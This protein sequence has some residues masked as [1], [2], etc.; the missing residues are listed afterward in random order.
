MRRCLEFGRIALES[1]DAPVGSLIVIGNEIIAEG[2][3]SVKSKN[4]PTAHAEIEAVR[5]ACVKSGALDL[6][7]ATLYT[8]VEP[9]VMCAY[10]IR[11][12]GIGR[13]IF[14]LPNDQVGGANSTFPVLTD[15]DFPLKFAPPEI[16]AGVL[17]A[18]CENLL[19]EFR[20]LRKIKR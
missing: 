18:E 19:R 5:R 2:R 13:V 16:R 15:S 20:S 4:D 9:C 11:Q 3:E 17:L 1:G 7:E 6:R 14:G 10:T 12:T 8:N